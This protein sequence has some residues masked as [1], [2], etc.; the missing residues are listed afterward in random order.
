[1]TQGQRAGEAT[2][3]VILAGFAPAIKPRQRGARR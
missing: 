1:M 2:R 3:L